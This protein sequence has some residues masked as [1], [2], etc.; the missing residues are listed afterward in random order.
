VYDNLQLI[1]H[2]L[3]LKLFVVEYVFY[4]SIVANFM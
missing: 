4:D 1:K 2:T 3:E